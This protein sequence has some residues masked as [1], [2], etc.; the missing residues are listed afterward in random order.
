[1]AV[2]RALGNLPLGC[3][4]DQSRASPGNGAPD[5]EALARTHE[6]LLRIPV[7]QDSHGTCQSAGEI[8]IERGALASAGHSQGDAKHARWVR[9]CSISAASPEPNLKGRCNVSNWPNWRA[10]R[11]SGRAAPEPARIPTVAWTL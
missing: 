7:S 5:R 8:G 4:A 9:S 11:T 1:M 2:A 10:W 6:L 3:D